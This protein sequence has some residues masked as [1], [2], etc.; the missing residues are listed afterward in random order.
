MH[1]GFSGLP[2]QQAGFQ[3]D[4]HGCRVEGS[5]GQGRRIL[6]ELEVAGQVL[7]DHLWGERGS[8]LA[9]SLAPTPQQAP[10]EEPTRG[11]SMGPYR[12][13]TQ[14][15]LS[16]RNCRKGPRQNRD[17]AALGGKCGPWGWGWSPFGQGTE[18]WLNTRTQGQ[19]LALD[20]VLACPPFPL[21]TLVKF[22]LMALEDKC[23]IMRNLWRLRT[24]RGP[25]GPPCPLLCP[26]LTFPR[27]PSPWAGLSST[28]TAGGHH[29][30]SHR[31]C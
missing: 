31:S 12:F 18:L 28:S 6:V 5:E 8:A 26:A 20:T 14:P 9:S 30:R 22:H 2:H 11:S 19:E 29:P 17:P 10:A 23:E 27:C 13:T 25:C 16:M 3:A 7:L 15:F 1:A 21:L 4:R 24:P